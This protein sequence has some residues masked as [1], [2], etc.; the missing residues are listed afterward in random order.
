MGLI[1]GAAAVV[2]SVVIFGPFA[3]QTH[4]SGAV[5]AVSQA[6][7][8]NIQAQVAIIAKAMPILQG[9]DAEKR[10]ILG[11]VVRSLGDVA[12]QV[13]SLNAA[14]S[15][16]SE[17]DIRAKIGELDGTVGTLT[18]TVRSLIS[19]QGQEANILN[20]FSGRL[21]A[22]RTELSGS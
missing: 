21:N 4:A 9:V 16:M 19:V 12:A 7:A 10:T 8:Q 13:R 1:A 18:S 20:Y 15:T 22:F 11:N 3:P 17:A 14:S 6:D 2:A 5:P